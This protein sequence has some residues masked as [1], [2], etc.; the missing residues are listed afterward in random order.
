MIQLRYNYIGHVRKR[1]SVSE[2]NRKV[3]GFKSLVEILERLD[4]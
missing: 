4:L 3:E 2:L 1:R